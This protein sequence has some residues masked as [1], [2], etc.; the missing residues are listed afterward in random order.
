MSRVIEAAIYAQMFMIIIALNVL[1]DSNKIGLPKLRILNDVSKLVQLEPFSEMSFV[2]YVMRLASS[3][4]Q[5]LIIIVQSVRMD[6]YKM[7]PMH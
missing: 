1:M 5:V 6:L 2:R 7:K 3:A 4:L